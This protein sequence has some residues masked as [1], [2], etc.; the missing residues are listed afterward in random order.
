L[1][2]KPRPECFR[3]LLT[4]RLR[5]IESTDLSDEEK[6]KVAISVTEKLV[7]SLH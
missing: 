6:I 3:C 4:T 5:E 1:T 7:E 2:V